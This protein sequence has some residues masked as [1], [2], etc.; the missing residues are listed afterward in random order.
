MTVG[1]Q[2][3][4]AIARTVAAK[5]AGGL[6]E[7]VDFIGGSGTRACASRR[8]TVG[9]GG[10]ESQGSLQSAALMASYCAGEME[11]SHF[12]ALARVLSPLI[13]QKL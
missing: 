1:D 2:N 13:F 4:R 11:L 9:E 6:Q 7:L 10:R 5:F 8:W 12:R 3:E